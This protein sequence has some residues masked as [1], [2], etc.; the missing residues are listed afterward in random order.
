MFLPQYQQSS[1]T[2]LQNN[3]QNYKYILYI[4]IFQLQY[5]V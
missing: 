3:R 2:P 1:F 5:E 4:L